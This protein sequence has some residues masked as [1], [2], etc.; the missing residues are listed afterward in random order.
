MM[1]QKWADLKKGFPNSVME[2]KMS[3]LPN[4]SIPKHG[5]WV[6][7]F[8]VKRGERMGEKESGH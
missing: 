5:G 1:I 3:L 7:V 2:N 8:L 4:Y 6:I